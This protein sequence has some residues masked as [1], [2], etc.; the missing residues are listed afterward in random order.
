MPLFDLMSIY[1]DDECALKV[2]TC[3]IALYIYFC[4]N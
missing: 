4:L 3:A 1:D 2:G